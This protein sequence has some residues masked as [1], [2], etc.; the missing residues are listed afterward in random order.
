MVDRTVIHWYPMYS[1]YASELKVKAE[2][3]I[4]GIENFVP[5][6]YALVN[7]G[8]ERRRELVPALHN[9]IFIRESREKITS[10]KMF[11]RVCIPLQYMMTETIGGYKDFMVISD[12]EMSNFMKVASQPS[13]QAAYLRYED[14]L[15]KEGRKVKIIDGNFAGVEGVVKRIRKDRVVVVLLKGI[16]AIAITEIK[17]EC[18][19]FLD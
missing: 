4:L 8:P 7:R 10:L 1:A 9:L 19:Q 15:N 3:D 12:D 2:L 14:F 17:P 5:M 11:N 6:K 18:L 16:A 13:E